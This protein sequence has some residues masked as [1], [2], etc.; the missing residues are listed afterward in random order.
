MAACPQTNTPPRSHMRGQFGILNVL[1]VLVLAASACVV[2]SVALLFVVP[3]IVPSFLRQPAEPGQVAIVTA[4]P[5]VTATA[6]SAYPT[7]PPAWTATPSP[8]PTATGTATP[9]PS[10]TPS[11][12]DTPTGLPTPITTEALNTPVTL[13]PGTAAA[14]QITAKSQANIRTGP[15]PAYPIVASLKAGQT[16]TVVGRDSGS[17]WFAISFDAAPGGTGWVFA[18]LV[19]YGGNINDLPVVQPSAPPP[20]TA[21]LPTNTPAATSIP[22]VN[23]IQTRYFQMV[24]TTGTTGQHM[25][26]KFQVVNI[27]GSTITYGI[28]AAHTDVGVTADSWHDPLLPGKVLTWDDHID[29]STSG[30]YQVYLGICFAAHD[31]CK[32]GSAPW[33]RLSN[34]VQVTIN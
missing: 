18:A 34:S 27:S 32:S 22:N 16:A 31:P 7:L 29:F 25:R 8:Q 9:I 14:N 11:P 28:L 4:M 10:A 15:S 12:S 33:T 30:V 6:T 3:G 20:P 26:F 17:I 13:V 2:A 21:V 1:T 23:G 24:D 19:T 5:V